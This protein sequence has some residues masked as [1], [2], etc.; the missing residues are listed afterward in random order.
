MAQGKG[1]VTD[2]DL[3]VLVRPFPRDFA[4]VFHSF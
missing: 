2:V 1:T 3:R 4:G